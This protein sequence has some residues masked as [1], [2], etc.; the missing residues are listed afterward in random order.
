MWQ[1]C[2]VAAVSQPWRSDSALILYRTQNNLEICKQ[3]HQGVTLAILHIS[4][5]YSA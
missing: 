1:L 2:Y 4:T 5:I 3:I